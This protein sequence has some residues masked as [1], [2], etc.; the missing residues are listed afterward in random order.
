MRWRINAGETARRAIFSPD[1]TLVALLLTDGN[2]TLLR[3]SDGAVLRTIPQATGDTLAFSPD[4]TLV[5]TA[6]REEPA[7][8]WRVA[9]GKQ[10]Q[11]VPHPQ[12]TVFLSFAADNTLAVRLL[13]PDPDAPLMVT[14]SSDGHLAAQ[15]SIGSTVDLR[16]TS[17]GQTLRTLRP[18]GERV[19][20]TAFSADGALVATSSNYPNTA[21]RVWRVAD[22]QQVASFTNHLGASGLVF[23]PDGRTLVAEE[24][25]QLVFWRLR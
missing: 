6:G 21:V 13:Q 9:D 18:P 23:A 1:G 10:L 14:F 7:Q 2:L 19:T 8:V 5:A 3:A 25:G 4:S 12:G 16:D 11:S 17:S 24:F 15:R 22:G 20:A